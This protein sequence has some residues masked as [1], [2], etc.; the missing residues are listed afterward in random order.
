[1]EPQLEN[2]QT[3]IKQCRSG[4]LH[5][6]NKIYQQYFDGL[7]R[8]AYRMLGN[9]E[10]A[11]DAIQ[12]AFIKLNKAISNFRS[13]AKLS[14]YIYRILFNVC[15]DLHRKKT[16]NE[17]IGDREPIFNPQN[18]LQIHLD[19]AICALPD[20]MRAC[21][22][23]FAIEGFKQDEIAEML[24]ISIGTV[25]AHIFQAKNKLKQALKGELAAI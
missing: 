18:E 15:Y 1:M 21:F 10:D 14:T 22:V 2:E 20:K 16:V 25:K 7:Y 12:I 13:E 3:I 8:T 17:R 6:F 23:L 19:E 11:D 24:D 5:A 4:D 9:R